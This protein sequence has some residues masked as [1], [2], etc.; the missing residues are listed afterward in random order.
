MIEEPSP[1]RAHDW[2]DHKPEFVDQALVEERLGQRNTAVD[3]DVA[4]RLTLEI[5]DE[6][7]ETGAND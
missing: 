2:G 6:R 3:P 1:L 7:D 5:D 4:T